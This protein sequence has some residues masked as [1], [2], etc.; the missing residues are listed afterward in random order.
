[1]HAEVR[2]TIGSKEARLTRIERG[3]VMDDEVW[4]TNSKVSQTEAK[5]ASQAVFDN[6]YDFLNFMFNGE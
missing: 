6:L 4:A 3:Q 2:L 5:G 1:M